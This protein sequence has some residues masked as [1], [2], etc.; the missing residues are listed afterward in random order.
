MKTIVTDATDAT[1]ARLLSMG[2]TLGFPG[3]A[4]RRIR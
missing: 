2:L 3:R 4:G 1:D